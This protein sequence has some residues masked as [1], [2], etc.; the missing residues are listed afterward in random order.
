MVDEPPEEVE[1]EEPA[2]PKLTVL[3]GGISD[4]PRQPRAA[5]LTKTGAYHG[6]KG[7][8]NVVCRIVCEERSGYAV[9]IKKDNL[10]GFIK[11]IEK[12]KLGSEILAKFVCVHRG[13]ALLSPIFQESSGPDQDT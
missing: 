9:V 5:Y 7:G 12:L 3:R 10:P 4:K 11:T 6:Y 1:E 2:K 13:R 8:R